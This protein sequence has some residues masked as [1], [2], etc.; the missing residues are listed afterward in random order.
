VFAACLAPLSTFGLDLITAIREV[1]KKHPLILAKQ[2]EAAAAESGLSF[3]QQQRLPSLAV[4]TNRSSQTNSKTYA[5]TRLQQPLYAGGRITAGIEQAEARIS[6]SQAMLSLARR[7]LMA[8]TVVAF[9]EV[10]KGEARLKVAHKSVEAHQVLLE[11]IGRRVSSEVSPRS[12]LMLTRSRLLQAQTEKTQIQL[13]LDR[14]KD[15]LSELLEQPVPKLSPPAYRPPLNIE[16]SQALSEAEAYAPEIRQLWAQEAIATLDV[17][18]QKSV[19]L[20]NVFLRHEILSGHRDRGLVREQTYI[21]LEFAP[22]AGL[23]VAQQIFAAESRKLAAIE[24][25]RA[26]EKDIRDRVRSAWADVHSLRLQLQSTRGYVEST[27]E[28][29]ESFARQFGIGRK[30]WVEVLN[31]TREYLQAELALVDIEWSL[32]VAELLLE[33]ETGRFAPHLLN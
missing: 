13:G 19:A 23:A 2:Q 31:A 16:L 24:A 28:V 15:L 5:T 29:S 27:Q 18:L 17:D 3:A 9:H 22:G 20:P 33:I 10:L 25:R 32:K 7:D 30:S 21:G 11:S 1:D 8:R 14:A 26:T 12:D 4:T 6:E